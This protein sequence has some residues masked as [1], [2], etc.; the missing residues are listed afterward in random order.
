MRISSGSAESCCA[1]VYVKSD[2]GEAGGLIGTLSGGTVTDCYTTCSVYGSSV[3]GGFVGS[4]SGGSTDD[5]CYCTGLVAG[6]N[7]AGSTLV[8]GSKLEGE[9]NRG[10]FAGAMS[11]GTLKG[12]YL[13]MANYRGTKRDDKNELVSTTEEDYLPALGTGTASGVKA[14]DEDA[15][16]YERFFTAG[17]TARV[18]TIEGRVYDPALNVLAEK[19]DDVVQ[20]GFRKVAAQVVHLG[21]WPVFET[22]VV[23]S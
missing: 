21:D 2:S 5:K 15:E 9:T 7:G 22:L 6:K 3:A 20:F 8:W 12:C 10:A 13:V 1:A 4:A 17:G 19:K 18:D 16:A 23:N 11:G 14:L